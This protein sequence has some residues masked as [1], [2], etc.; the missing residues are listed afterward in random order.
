MSESFWTFI[1]NSALGILAKKNGGLILVIIFCVGLLG[2]VFYDTRISNTTLNKEV[3]DKI[4]QKDSTQMFYT[5]ELQ[6]VASELTQLEK[7]LGECKI[8]NAV[9]TQRV[10]DC[11]CK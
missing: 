3:G 8:S 1:T 7:D 2:W 10:K 9:L 11:D 6:K 5:L 4:R